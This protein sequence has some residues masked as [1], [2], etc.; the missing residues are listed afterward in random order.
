MRCPKTMAMHTSERSVGVTA[1]AAL[2]V[3]VL[4]ALLAVFRMSPVQ[5]AATRATALI[6]STLI[7]VPHDDANGG[8]RDG[9]GEKAITP[10][11]RVRAVGRDQ[12]SA[13]APPSQSTTS[14]IE[15]P[16]EITALPVKPIGDAMQMIPGAI[17]TH[18]TS[19]GPGDANVGTGP[20]DEPGGLGTRRGPGFGDGTTP[21]GPGVTM[22][23]LIERVAPKY[24]VEAM[25]ARIQGVA[26]VECIVLPDGTVGDA[27]IIRSL[28]RRFGLDQE[29]L[30]AARRWRFRPGRLNGKPVPVVVTIELMFNVR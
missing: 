4:C 28:D 24:T 12:S 30:A 21:Y 29:A 16:D 26:M 20:G 27:R 25:Q 15:P 18:G 17:E 19:A 5:D 9:G 8:G 10:P 6:P 7:W 14:M 23:T 11:R 13:T 1:S 2:H 3:A 22:P